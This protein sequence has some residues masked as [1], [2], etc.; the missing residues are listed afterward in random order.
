MPAQLW[1]AVLQVD[2]VTPI[3]LLPPGPA[4]AQTG[5]KRRTLA[6]VSQYDLGWFV[7]RPHRPQCQDHGAHRGSIMLAV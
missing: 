1:G 5:E 4:Q 6:V 2:P 3:R 7:R